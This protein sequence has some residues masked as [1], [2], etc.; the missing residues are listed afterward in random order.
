[1]EHIKMLKTSKGLF[2]G[3]SV[4]VLYLHQWLDWAG[5][6]NP[7]T[8]VALPMIQRGSVW[9][10]KQIIDLW[11]SLLRGMPLGS[12]LVNIM[13][14]GSRV[15]SITNGSSV[16][17]VSTINRTTIGLV[18]GQQR[19]LSMLIAWPRVG[20]K[21]DRRIWVDFTSIPHPDSEALFNLSVTT[22]N[23]PF[24]FKNYH[25]NRLSREDFRRA[26]A[27]YEQ[28][29]PDN[30]T[31]KF[32]YGQPW[33]SRLSL[34]LGWLIKQWQ[35]KSHQKAAWVECVMAKMK[36][37]R[38]LKLS[39][40]LNPDEIKPAS[41]KTWDS[42][43][44]EEQSITLERIE[45]FADALQ[46]LYNLEVPFIKLD[47]KFFEEELSSDDKID[48]PLA[49]LFKRIGTGGT[50][51]SN[52]DYAYSMIKHRLPDAYELVEKL[53]KQ[54]NVA[55]L[56]S[57]TDLVMTVLRLVAAEQSL[58]DRGENLNKQEFLRLI[59]F[60]GFLEQGFLPMFKSGAIGEA[61]EQLTALLRYDKDNNKCGLPLHA[62]PLLQRS[63]I[64]VLLRWI[65]LAKQSSDDCDQVYS[66]SKAEILRFVMFWQ[67]CVTDK[68]KAS[69]FA[70]EKL[71][72]STKIFP[73]VEIYLYLLDK[74]VAI[75]LV[76]PKQISSIKGLAFSPEGVRLRGWKRF[77]RRVDEKEQQMVDL[78]SR[79][80]N[81][82][83]GYKHTLL[84]W[85]Q[86]Q[87]V[88]ETFSGNPVAGRDEETP[89]DYDHI[90]PK[91]H[92]AD[93]TGT[94]GENRFIDFFEC[95][96]DRDYS[97]IGNSIGNI[98]V[99]DSSENRRLGSKSPY[100]KLRLE[101]NDVEKE[102]LQSAVALDQVTFWSDC[103]GK[104]DIDGHWINAERCWDLP[105]VQAFQSAVEHRT[106]DL[107][108]R[109]FTD[110]SFEC[111]TCGVDTNAKE[112]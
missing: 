19:T 39:N 107:Y 68:E 3:R 16:E 105:R 36:V 5:G 98:R 45:R 9:K 24:G 30:L 81:N 49:I 35:E 84:L 10:P 85:L 51:L 97:R 4:D 25:S 69:K 44:P 54:H 64:Q 90:C 22:Q 102:L 91:D 89:Y 58:T 13:R 43:L 75:P 71:S 29:N 59:R 65:R 41:W 14:E 21:M 55:S 73:G 33:D 82:N 112:I 28:E 101:D 23:H 61:F 17:T 95:E 99:L 47:E 108:Q 62:Y 42:L 67:L 34:E 66:D 18:D 88:N 50:E 74:R 20:E 8:F 46:R 57:D 79:W 72:L 86:R 80:W 77:E 106:F 31:E 92:W 2:D 111:W 32:I 6:L 26:L 109:F 7:D 1:M 27:S 110:L 37:I 104:K 76:S 103:S 93:W 63:L 83:V 53:K 60:P 87:L 70:Y 94:R 100:E 12:F 40:S 38:H 52:A 48:P 78:Y 15:H 56:L 11:D 96:D